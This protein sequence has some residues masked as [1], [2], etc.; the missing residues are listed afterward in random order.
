MILRPEIHPYETKTHFQ[1][2]SAARNSSPQN[3]NSNS[4][5]ILRPEI[6]PHETKKQ[7]QDDSAAR[8]SS[9]QNKIAILG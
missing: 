9:P 3:K 7:F 8:N 6:H 5:M 2:D 4:R 1:D